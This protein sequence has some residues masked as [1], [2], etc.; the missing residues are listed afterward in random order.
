MRVTVRFMDP[1]KE[2][3]GG[4]TLELELRE[5][6]SYGEALDEIDRRLG[7]RLPNRI[8]DSS[9]RDFKAGILVMGEGRDLTDRGAVLRDGEEIK[10]LP[11][12]GGG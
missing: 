1:L 6:A 7:S 8:W 11:M 4:D 2:F 10:V 5:G 12:L 3:A 9:A